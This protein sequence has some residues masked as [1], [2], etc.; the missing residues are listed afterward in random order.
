MDHNQRI[1]AMTEGFHTNCQT[2]E[3]EICFLLCFLVCSQFYIGQLLDE[4]CAKAAS[5]RTDV[6]G[7]DKSG[8]WPLN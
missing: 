4:A 7:S 1:C 6:I 2:F 3:G 5:V 8:V